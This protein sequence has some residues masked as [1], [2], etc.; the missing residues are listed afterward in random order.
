[1]RNTIKMII[2]LTV[3]GLVSGAALVSMYKYAHPLIVDNQKKETKKAIFV[4]FPG[5]KSY[6]E[7]NIGEDVIFKVKDK[8]GSLLGYTFLAEGNG[9]Q[10]T[11]KLMAGIKPDM[12]T[13]VG[14]E[15]LESQETPGLGQEITQDKFKDQ[16]KGLNA[17][18]EITYVK[19]KKP[20]KPNEIQAITG[21]TISSRA[22]VTIL[23][24]KI[25]T[26]KKYAKS[27]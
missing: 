16:F 17:S 5:A 4:I 21:A 18:P 19:N 3:V 7:K 14:I 8:K 9:Y 15:I 24:E 13:L 25:K 12:E 2:V 1:M 20:E 22:V 11:I 10:G 26:I 27:L 6:E 23:N